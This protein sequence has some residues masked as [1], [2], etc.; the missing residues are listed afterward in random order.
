MDSVSSFFFK[1]ISPPGTGK[2]ALQERFESERFIWLKPPEDSFGH[3][4]LRSD[5]LKIR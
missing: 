2:A 1:F 5:S 4:T 3:L